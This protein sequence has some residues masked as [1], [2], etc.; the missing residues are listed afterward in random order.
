MAPPAHAHPHTHEEDGHH[1]FERM[2]AR[3]SSIF[4]YSV[5]PSTAAGLNSRHSS[6]SNANIK[7]SPSPGA[8]SVTGSLDSVAEQLKALSVGNKLV[9][10][11]PSTKTPSP[12]MSPS[13]TS[14]PAPPPSVVVAVHQPVAVPPPPPQPAISAEDL[15]DTL[16]GRYEVEDRCLEGGRLGLMAIQLKAGISKINRHLKVLIKVLYYTLEM[17]AFRDISLRCHSALL[18]FISF[19]QCVRQIVDRNGLTSAEE[20]CLSQEFEVL[21]AW[22]HP[23]IINAYDIFVTD[24]QIATVMDRCDGGTLMQ[25]L[26]VQPNLCLQMVTVY[27]SQPCL[28]K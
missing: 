5:D 6:I 13:P 17:V 22:T 8:V 16:E 9:H 20:I 14:I 26:M 21:R 19:H 27:S 23:N 2:Y 25:R 1:T 24:Q 18:I 28:L 4:S 3:K 12:H 11:S 10:S 7:R 15:P